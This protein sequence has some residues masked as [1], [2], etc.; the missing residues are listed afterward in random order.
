MLA[1][2]FGPYCWS[3][4][5]SIFRSYDVRGRTDTGQID[6]A[7]MRRIG[8]VFA[9]HVGGMAVAVGRDV[10][11][12]SRELARGFI[13]GVTGAGADVMDLGEVPTEVVTHVSGSTGVAGAM[14][15]ASHNP[16]NYNGVKLT[17]PHAV[18][19]AGDTGLAEIGR[20]V[21]G[22]WEAPPVVPGYVEPVGDVI[23]GYLDHLLSRHNPPPL[24]MVID[25]GNG[26]VGMVIPQLVARSRLEVVPL[27]LEPD[28]TFPNHPA[29]P[30]NQENLAELCDLVVESG[31]PLGAAFDGDAD[32]VF[33]VDDAGMVLDGSAAT[34]ILAGYFLDAYPGSKVVHNPIV[35]DVVPRFVSD[36]GGVPLLS[37]VGHSNMKSVMRQS[38]AVFGGEHSGH[39][40]FGEFYGADSGVMALLTMAEIVG[41]A[42]APLSSLRREV[43]TRF[44]SGEVNYTVGDVTTIMDEMV[45]AFPDA[46]VDRTDGVTLRWADRRVNV[47]PSNTEPLLRVNVEADEEDTLNHVL[48]AMTSIIER[49][50]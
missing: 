17:A 47:R 30:L 40:Y 16:P 5:P 24:R 19:I 46:D 18:P 6:S 39:F 49:A 43:P 44:S 45:N 20:R 1:E 29:D 28:G 7:T 26:M 37:S 13:D 25:G 32:R 11:P 23:D 42:A 41:A 2:H 3:V 35:S 48:A 14:I 38:G 15:T 4:D 31:V 22:D 34:A 33:F 27:Y 21:V 8:E 12:T 10:R 50:G 36:R 9:T